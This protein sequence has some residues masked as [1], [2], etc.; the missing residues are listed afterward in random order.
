M[1]RLCQVAVEHECSRVEWTTD[2][3]NPLPEA[4][5]EQLGMP[6]NQE[7]ICYRLEGDDLRR[8]AP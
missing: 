3:D 8:M 5:Y 7:K 6:K 4:F 1:Q 2:Q